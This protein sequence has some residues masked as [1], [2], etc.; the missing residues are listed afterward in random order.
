M[1]GVGIGS[2]LYLVF[3]QGSF[4]LKSKSCI[5]HEQMASIMVSKTLIGVNTL[6]QGEVF[7]SAY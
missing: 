6:S 3:F 7:P 5:S 2:P 4:M 1:V